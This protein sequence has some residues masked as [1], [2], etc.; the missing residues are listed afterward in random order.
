M[1]NLLSTT[2]TILSTLPCKV[3][4]CRSYSKYFLHLTLLVRSM[5]PLSSSRRVS[6]R[7]TR[8]LPS[9]R[10]SVCPSVLRPFCW[11]AVYVVALCPG[12]LLAVYCWFARAP[13]RPLV[14]PSSLLQA[15]PALRTCVR[16]S[17]LNG[18][19]SDLSEGI[20]LRD[21]V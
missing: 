15:S 1:L 16:L 7:F 2:A 8:F 10:L 5:T 21:I 17:L 13:A 6:W 9:E 14:S 19:Y 12:N 18:Q 11:P 4:T 3:F 20:G